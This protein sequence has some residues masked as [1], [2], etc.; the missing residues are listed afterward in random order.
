[1]VFPDPNPVY[2]YEEHVG[3]MCSIKLQVILEA[4]LVTDEKPGSN[5]HAAPGLE[6][7]LPAELSK[8]ITQDLFGDFVDLPRSP[9]H[10]NEKSTGPVCALTHVRVPDIHSC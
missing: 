4:C 7:D 2:L 1:M 5:K 9:G 3:I 6:I 8:S 10:F